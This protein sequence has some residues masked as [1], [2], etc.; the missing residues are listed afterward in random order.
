M[1]M[2]TATAGSDVLLEY[3]AFTLAGLGAEDETRSLAEAFAP[4]QQGPH[5]LAA[6]AAC[7]LAR[8]VESRSPDVR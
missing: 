6:V 2:P 5:R 8:P 7:G 1:E 4:R 3:G